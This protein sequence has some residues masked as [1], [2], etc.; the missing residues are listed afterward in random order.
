MDR[1]TY[2]TAAC[3][4]SLPAF[5]GCTRG[6]GSTGRVRTPDVSIESDPVDPRFDLSVDVNTEQEFSKSEP[7][8]IEISLTNT[9]T[10]PQDFIFGVSPPFSEFSPEGQSH[11]LLLPENHPSSGTVPEEPIDGCW[12]TD[13]SVTKTHAMLGRTVEPNAAIRESYTLIGSQ[14]N[15]TCLPSGEYRFVSDEYL[16]LDWSWGFIVTIE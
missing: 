8:Q 2:L 5:G 9:G 7:A 13:G 3:A 14:G 12:Q 6:I 16:G 10:K 11:V 15:E 4:T 1:R